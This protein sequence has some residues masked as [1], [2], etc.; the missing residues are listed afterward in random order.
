MNTGQ[1]TGKLLFLDIRQNRQYRTVTSKGQ[2]TS[3]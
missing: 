2:D 1:N 3:K